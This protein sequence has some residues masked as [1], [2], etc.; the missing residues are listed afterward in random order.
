MEIPIINFVEITTW[1]DPT[2]NRSINRFSA[3]VWHG[4]SP[5]GIRNISDI[6][7]NSRQLEQDSRNVQRNDNPNSN[8]RS[9]KNGKRRCV[10]F[11]SRIDRGKSLSS[12]EWL[13]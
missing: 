7:L 13:L 12:T 11:S 2:R 4:S 1:G 10:S 6:E 8:S 5:N 3:K 9:A